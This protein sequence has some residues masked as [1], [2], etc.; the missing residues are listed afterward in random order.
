MKTKNEIR[1]GNLSRTI[2]LSIP[3][4]TYQVRAHNLRY[5]HGTG[6]NH[7]NGQKHKLLNKTSAYG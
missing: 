5:G 1:S 2:D 3:R 6:K 4:S 7:Q